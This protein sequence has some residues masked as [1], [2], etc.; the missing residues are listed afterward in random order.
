MNIEA[1]AERL[2]YLASRTE[3]IGDREVSPPAMTVDEC[4]KVVAALRGVSEYH[5]PEQMIPREA[6]VSSLSINA[7]TW[8]AGAEAMRD[9][10]ALALEAQA[11]DCSGPGYGMA[12]D[13]ERA[14]MRRTKDRARAA[15]EQAESE[16][17]RLRGDA[18]AAA[19]KARGAALGENPNL[20]AL[21]FKVGE[22]HVWTEWC[23]NTPQIGFE[24][25]VE[26]SGYWE[27]VRIDEE[28]T[29]VALN[30]PDL[31]KQGEG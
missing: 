28:L 12:S 18:E 16:A 22:D 4:R 10:C 17:I 2:A 14:F 21:G 13:N 25:R 11:P 23:W 20:V 15:S 9:A 6:C 3:S 26:L 1:Y 24:G 7:A 27:F 30:I 29:R 8:N 5:E 19:I 31:S